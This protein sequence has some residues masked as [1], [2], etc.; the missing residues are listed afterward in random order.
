VHGQVLA[1]VQ[2]D[3][4]AEIGWAQGLD[5]PALFVRLLTELRRRGR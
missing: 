3:H 5:A 4:W 1:R 2:A